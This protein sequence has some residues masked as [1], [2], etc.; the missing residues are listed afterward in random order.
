MKKLNNKKGFTLVEL[1][2][3]IAIIGILAAILIPT[4]LN[5]LTRSHVSNANTVAGKLRDNVTYFLTKAD[6]DGYGMFLS[7]NATCDVYI[8]VVGSVWNVTTSDKTVFVQHYDTKW[9]GSGQGFY[10]DGN[11]GSTNAENRLASY[12]SE[13]FR[14]IEDGY[15][16]FR[17][18]GGVCMALYY[19][20]DQT[21]QVTEMP[22]FGSSNGWSVDTFQWDGRND[23]ITASGITVG[24]SP[25][26]LSA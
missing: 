11:A 24:T 15:I 17:L 5:Y 12:L 18:V 22:A 3:V 25:V 1:I 26:L 6:A 4:M 9:T 14:D 21:S 23:G 10:G 7:H 16:E 13:V 19:T 8:S 2:V 20:P